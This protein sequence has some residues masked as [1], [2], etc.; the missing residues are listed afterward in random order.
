MGRVATAP[1]I[2]TKAI[3]D[4]LT[5]DQPAI[6]AERYGI[7]AGTVRQWKKRL[8]TPAVTQSV[9]APVTARP[10]IER[11]QLDIATLVLDNLR[12]K[13]IATQKIAEHVTTPTWL[14]KQNA[15][16]VAALFETVDR[17]AVAIL[18]RMARGSRA[19]DT[20]RSDA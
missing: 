15:A 4:L 13:L 12:A 9:T 8:V 20:D 6:V 1:A 18:D 3:A 10:A 2:K 11:A 7:P 19:D 16:D 14:E 17:A 5:G